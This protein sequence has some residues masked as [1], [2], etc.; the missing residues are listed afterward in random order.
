MIPLMIRIGAIVPHWPNLFLSGWAVV[1]SLTKSFALSAQ[2]AVKRMQII[3]ID[4]SRVSVMPDDFAQSHSDLICMFV[5]ISFD[6]GPGKLPQSIAIGDPFHGWTCAGLQQ[7]CR[8]YHGA[9]VA[10]PGHGSQVWHGLLL[11]P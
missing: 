4:S 6:T 5:S 10:R 9:K 3:G 7:D 11:G 8:P 2:S 1:L